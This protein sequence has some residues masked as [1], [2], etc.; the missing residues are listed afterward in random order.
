M[1]TNKGGHFHPFIFYTMI[2]CLFFLFSH[3]LHSSESD[4]VLGIFNISTFYG[5][6]IIHAP[7]STGTPLQTIS[8]FLI[9]TS[10]RPQIKK[11]TLIGFK[12]SDGSEIYHHLPERP[13]KYILIKPPTVSDTR[14]VFGRPKE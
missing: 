11:T 4:R 13:T 5:S 12:L 9:P 6:K 7:V 14:T 8:Q 1:T 2:I 10:D 3:T